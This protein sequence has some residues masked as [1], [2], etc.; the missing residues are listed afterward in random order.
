MQ[1]LL[2]IILPVFVVIG[3]GYAVTWRGW[4]STSAVDGLVKFTQHFAIPCLLFQAI[5][6][7]DLDA[8]LNLPLL[9]TFYTGALICFAL[10]VVGARVLFA[11]NAT[12]AI[13]IGF[14]CLFSNSVLL[15]LPI[16]ERA[17]GP[18]ALVGN[19]AIIAFHAPLLYLVGVSAMEL[20]QSKGATPTARI[21]RIGNA[22]FHNP[23]VIAIALGFIV[24]VLSIP[25]PA[26]IAAG[27]G[28]MAAA[29]L[30]AALFSLGGVLFQYRPEGDLRTIAMVCTISLIV[31]PVI[32]WTLGTALDLE[33]DAFRSALVTSAMAP[34]ANAY[35][36][37]NMYGAARRVAASS[38]L[39]ATAASTITVWIWLI[40]IP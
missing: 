36:F 17:F 35:V 26:P 13:A 8:A 28:L 27:V 18:D 19:F 37:A 9:V 32:V 39:I 16:T 23:L 2:D 22:M 11:R 29:A 14:C 5:A 4:F 12:D 30:P 3:F 38:V 24:N 10:G 6:K 1:A 25:V 31:H 33:R 21:A 34:G 20:V 40:V 15:G 7:I